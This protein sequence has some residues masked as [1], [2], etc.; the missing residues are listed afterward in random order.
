MINL[1]LFK[2]TGIKLFDSRINR[3]QLFRQ[4]VLLI[5]SLAGTALL[6]I[7]CAPA[8]D[9]TPQQP[10]ISGENFQQSELVLLSIL[11]RGQADR[12][13]GAALTAE[14]M[15]ITQA[16][17]LENDFSTPGGI[18]NK[19]GAV[20]GVDDCGDSRSCMPVNFKIVDTTKPL[21]EQIGLGKAKTISQI[22]TQPAI[23]QTGINEGMV[24][25][26]Q[27]C[28]TNPKGCGAWEGMDEILTHGEAGEAA[29]TKHGVTPGTLNK[30]KDMVRLMKSGGTFN[31]DDWLKTVAEVQAQINTKAHGVNY[32]AFWGTY[33]H[34]DHTFTVKGGIDGAG[35]IYTS[36]EIARFPKLQ[37]FA[38]ALDQPTEIIE[39]IARGQ[40]PSFAILHGS[41][42]YS[43][44][45]ILGE[46]GQQ[47]GKV[48]KIGVEMNK[49]AVTAAEAADRANEF[50]YS[51]GVLQIK[52]KMVFVTAHNAADMDILM[53]AL[54]KNGGE[55]LPK[56]LADGGK[57]VQTT[58]DSSG[59]IAQM[60][61]FDI[62]R[63]TKVLKFIKDG[64][65]TARVLSRNQL[66]Q[67]AKTGTY[68][69]E[70][71]GAVIKTR[72]DRA[73]KYLLP[74][75]KYGLRFIGDVGTVYQVVE[76]VDKWRGY[77][78]VF[79]M[80]ARPF[81][82]MFF[83]NYRI[84]T[85]Q[86]AMTISSEKGSINPYF[87]AGLI[88]RFQIPKEALVTTYAQAV[89]AY[90]DRGPGAS[91]SQEP[92]NQL[93]PSEVGKALI[94]QIPHQFTLNGME[95]SLITSFIIQSGTNANGTFEF[96]DRDPTKQN[97]IVR[98]L[99]TGASLNTSKPGTQLS[100]LAVTSTGTIY[101]IKAVVGPKG[102]INIYID[103][104]VEQ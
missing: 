48:F 30:L 65:L 67:I 62:R 94:I 73:V 51:V 99:V 75:A 41:K 64:G 29:L 97:M 5:L 49:T 58:L 86:E 38:M 83:N 27:A 76:A 71:V 22:G 4:R 37:S 12:L 18:F 7:A 35:R 40:T 77:E 59:R 84:L 96:D 36:A 32:T 87:A 46:L 82:T 57:I 66:D 85:T 100:S 102:E 39:S 50:M 42:Q 69:G 23:H 21:K 95:E 101:K 8:A 10:V 68:T 56:F 13:T 20:I 47:Q 91:H 28:W 89:R 9:L 33:G 92:W 98:D 26:H 17:L 3:L 1:E 52:G 103:G 63:L 54:L 79:E 14:Q 34:A 104:A 53:T 80:K 55:A 88:N 72:L 60:D 43:A 11:T 44:A 6:P 19:D 31:P 81:E 24:V 70:A 61:V 16:V 45:E 74:L 15:K 25:G 2:H 90:I 78:T 93:K